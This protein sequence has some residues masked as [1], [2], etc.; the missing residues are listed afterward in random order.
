MTNKTKHPREGRREKAFTQFATHGQDN[1]ICMLIEFEE[2]YPVI[3]L[4]NWTSDTNMMYIIKASIDYLLFQWYEKSINSWK[5]HW[6]VFVFTN[7]LI[8]PQKPRVGE[9][10]LNQWTLNSFDS[11]LNSP[12]RLPYMPVNSGCKNSVVHQ[13]DIC[14][15]WFSLFSLTDS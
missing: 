9:V 6:A 11:V 7:F 4:N 14:S 13:G 12:C 10:V 8:S 1:F 3:K 5:F 15:W 2:N